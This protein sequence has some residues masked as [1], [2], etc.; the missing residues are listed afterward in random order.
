MYVVNGIMAISIVH[1]KTAK[2]LYYTALKFAIS[3]EKF[4][5]FT[6]YL[7]YALLEVFIMSI[8]DIDYCQFSHPSFSRFCLSCKNRETEHVN[9]KC[10]T[11]DC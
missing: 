4:N 2:P 3:C 7:P 1:R 10:F 6:F 8:Y 9:I 11:A 5:F